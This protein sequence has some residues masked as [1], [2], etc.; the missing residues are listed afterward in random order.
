[1]KINMTI[2]KKIFNQVSLSFFL[3]SITWAENKKLKLIKFLET[4]GLGK[5]FLTFELN[6]EFQKILKLSFDI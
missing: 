6:A 4:S 1:M 2:S 3:S 5:Q